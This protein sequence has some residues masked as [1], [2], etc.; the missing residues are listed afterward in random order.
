MPNTV[1]TEFGID[2]Y[3][4]IESDNRFAFLHLHRTFLT[5]KVNVYRLFVSL[6]AVG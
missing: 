4:Q 2:P 6:H 5:L 3:N 1:Y